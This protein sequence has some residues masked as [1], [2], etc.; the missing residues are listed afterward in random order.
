MS[1]PP[2]LVQF[3]LIRAWKRCAPGC[4]ADRDGF[5]RGFW[6]DVARVAVEMA[7]AEDPEVELSFRPTMA[8]TRSEL[9]IPYQ[10]AAPRSKAK[11]RAEKTAALLEGFE[12]K[13]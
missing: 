13:L 8:G 6:P 3:Y 7:M 5:P 11:S 10:P 12:L 4:T 2:D 1:A 9:G